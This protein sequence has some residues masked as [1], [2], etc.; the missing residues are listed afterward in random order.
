MK[1]NA[2]KPTAFFAGRFSPFHD[3]HAA[4]VDKLLAEGK[5]VCIAIRDTPLSQR[6]PFS[7]AD[8]ITMIRARYQL[9]VSI[10]VIPDIAEIVYGRDVGYKIREIRLGDDL[11]AISATKIRALR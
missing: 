2:Q 6:D 8:R 11:E 7:M 9:G 1:M 3:G 4:I 5:E 10:V